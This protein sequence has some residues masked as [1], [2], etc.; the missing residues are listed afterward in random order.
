[1]NRRTETTRTLRHGAIAICFVLIVYLN[2]SPL[3]AGCG[4]YVLV[5]GRS[6]QPVGWLLPE[7]RLHATSESFG[8]SPE[9]RVWSDE[10]FHPAQ[11]GAE[12]A[13]DTDHHRSFRFSPFV[14]AQ[15]LSSGLMGQ[16]VGQR[17]RNILPPGPSHQ[18]PSTPCRGPYCSNQQST[19]PMV[20]TDRVQVSIDQ[21]A[22]LGSPSTTVD[23][24][25]LLAWEWNPEQGFAIATSNQVFRPPR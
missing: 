1:M 7:Q 8:I 22:I 6:H 9:F 16:L 11:T 15:P 5:A 25:Q 14:P 10:F 20:P 12:S 4:D 21:W 2:C 24:D 23:S 19:P 13:F 18:M 17:V 3:Q